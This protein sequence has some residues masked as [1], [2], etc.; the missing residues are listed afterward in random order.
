MLSV[1][2]HLS[3]LATAAQVAA[4][5]F[6]FSS[7]GHIDLVGSFSGASLYQDSRQRSV[8]TT[9][10]SGG[11]YQQ[12]S[13]GVYI[14]LGSTD[15]SVTTSC[16]ITST[17]AQPGPRIYLGGQFSNVAG[18]NASNV[19]AYDPATGAFSSLASGLSGPVNALYCDSKQNLVYI[20]GDFD[21]TN[22][23]NAVVWSPANG[24]FSQLPFGGF[25]GLMGPSSH[26][27]ILSGPSQ[28]TRFW[29]RIGQA[30]HQSFT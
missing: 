15:G 11:L 14:P 23:S 17:T 5:A 9:N 20:G 30:M 25:N 29:H 26:K 13:P 10:S 7:L 24:S 1:L 28:Q 12:V 3:G 22:S 8:L 4:P 21:A 16:T 2:L 27:L 19:V 18:T 6:D